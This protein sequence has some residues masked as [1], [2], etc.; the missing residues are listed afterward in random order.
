MPRP[1]SHRF[2]WLLDNPVRALLT[3]PRTLLDRLPLESRYHVLEVGPGSGFFS[4]ELARR[5]PDGH[6]ELLDVQAEMLAKARRKLE[7]HGIGNVGY[8]VADAG[9]PLPFAA[10]RFD[11]AL[12]VAVLGEIPDQG[13]A[14]SGLAKVLK[15]GGILAIHEMLPDPDRIPFRLLRVLVEA[16][17]FSLVAR[18]GPWWDYTALFRVGSPRTR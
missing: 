10:E 6:L 5:V 1:F 12:L 14:V 13:A 15:P 8:T 2:A 11:L 4:P 17:G 7:R 9:R 3:S 18:K 16:R